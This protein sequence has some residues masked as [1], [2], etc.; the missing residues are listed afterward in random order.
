MGL[1]NPLMA[2]EL[3]KLPA[4]CQYCQDFMK[5]KEV[6]EILG[7]KML[8]NLEEE[9]ALSDE[10]NERIKTFVERE[11]SNSGELNRV[12]YCCQNIDLETLDPEDVSTFIASRDSECDGL[13]QACFV[14]K[15]RLTPEDVEIRYQQEVDKLIEQLGEEIHRLQTGLEA[16]K[17]ICKRDQEKKEIGELIIDG[18]EKKEDMGS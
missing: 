1:A 13:S 16:V 18:I 5:A 15:N 7:K 11:T 4:V 3:R 12:G 9:H 2:L 17:E 6:I 14:F 8:T 10:A